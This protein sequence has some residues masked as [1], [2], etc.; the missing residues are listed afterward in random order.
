MK[1]QKDILEEALSEIKP[2]NQ[3]YVDKNLDIVEQINHLLKEKGWTQKIL[4]QKL[5]KTESEISKWLSGMHNLTLKSITNIETVL[6]DDIIVTPQQVVEKWE[7][8]KKRS[9][10][11][12]ISDEYLLK[13]EDFKVGFIKGK[14]NSKHI[15]SNI[16]PSAA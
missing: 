11:K 16:T 8:G 13:S 15:D 5:N 7:L 14:G 12:E 10:K 2:E 4:A 1:K 9:V 6:E 3:R